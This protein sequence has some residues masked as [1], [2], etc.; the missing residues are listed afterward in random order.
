MAENYFVTFN[1]DR[2]L[3]PFLPSERIFAQHLLPYH[4]I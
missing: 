3:Q 4:E 1:N 2:A